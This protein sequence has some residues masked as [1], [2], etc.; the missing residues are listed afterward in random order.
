[1]NSPG[2]TPAG[3]YSDSFQLAALELLHNGLLTHPHRLGCPF[4]RQPRRVGVAGLKARDICWP[5]LNAPRRRVG[6][7][8]ASQKA[9]FDPADH[10]AAVDA[11]QLSRFLAV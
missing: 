10:C 6:N 2:W 3:L 8:P 5:D 1:M 4:Q 11:Q 9:R 7:L